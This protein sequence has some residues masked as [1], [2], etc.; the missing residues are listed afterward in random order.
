VVQECETATVGADGRAAT[1]TGLCTVVPIGGAGR[2]RGTGWWWEG[3][4]GVWWVVAAVGG[5]GGLV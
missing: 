4:V 5:V 1:V 3:I 2:V